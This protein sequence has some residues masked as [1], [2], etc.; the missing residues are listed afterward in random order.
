MFGQSDFSLS[1]TWSSNP[2]EISV[3][4]TFG[5]NSVLTTHHFFSLSKSLWALAWIIA[6]AS[7]QPTA[8]SLL[9][10][11]L[12]T[13]TV[14]IHW[15]YVRSSYS[16]QNLTVSSTSQRIKARD[17]KLVSKDLNDQSSNSI[18]QLPVLFNHS[19][20]SDSLPFIH[21]AI[22]SYNF[23]MYS[24]HAGHLLFP[25]LRMSFL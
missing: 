18:L 2:E 1:L 6:T 23:F 5:I 15:E 22:D 3:A 11:S 25:L 16:T 7:S 17:L 21:F 19:N 13:E 10:S 9:Q 4:S 8:A 12:N 20:L 14:M 24:E